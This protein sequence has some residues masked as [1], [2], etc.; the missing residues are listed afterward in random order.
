M[1]VPKTPLLMIIIVVASCFLHVKAWHGQTY[2]GGNAAPRCQLRYID[3]PEECPTEMFPNSQN[4]ICWVDCFKPLCMAVC[5][6]IK[7]NCESYGSI[8]LDPRFIGGDGIV[9]YF[10]GKS[11]EHFSIV[12]D[13]DFQINARFTGHR[14]AGRTRDFTWIQALGFLFNSHKFSLETIKVATWDSNLDHLKFTIDGQDLVIPQETLSTW[15]S[16]DK[17]IKIERLTQKNSVIVTIKDK[18]EI[19]VNVVPVTK[20]DDRI[21]NYKLPVDDC[22]AHLEVQFKFINLSPKVDG[23]L[24]RTYRPDFKNPAKPGVAMP[25]VGGEDNFRTSSL[26]SHDCKTCLFSEDP[27]IA[28][29]SVKPKSTYTLLDCSRGA[30]SGLKFVKSSSLMLIFLVVMLCFLRAKSQGVYCSNPYERCFQKYIL[31]PQECPTTGAANSMNRVCYVD[32][33]K[34]LCNSECRSGDGIVFYFHGKS[35]EHFSLVSDPEFQINARFTGHRPVGRSR[36]FTWIQAL[37][38]LFNSHK[39]SLEATKVATWDS[40][41]V[42]LRFSFNGQELVIPEETLS[43]WYSLEKDIKIERPRKMNSVTITIKDKAEIMVNV[44]PVTKEDDMIHSYKVPLDN[45]FA[46]LEVQFRFFNLSPKVDGIL[47]RTYRT[48]FQNPAKPGVAMPVVG[49]EDN[50]RTSSLLSHDCKTCIFTGLSGS[51]KWETKKYALLDCTRGASSGYGI[52][53]RK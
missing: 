19:M 31:C 45:C 6:A 53:C 46:H 34:P 23:I 50:F 7:P 37:G 2:C 49:G 1:E 22:F 18:A 24:G 38:F 5:R 28:S 52:I 32:C 15:Y 21:H 10:H 48:D 44:V 51:V 11:N 43:T 39:L 33:S 3:C 47:G 9:F 16:S 12:S 36:D 41:I 40:G 30:S 26:L 17:D 25:V 8:C 4:K 35:N 20:E 29:G 14:P 27:A 42:H 13:P